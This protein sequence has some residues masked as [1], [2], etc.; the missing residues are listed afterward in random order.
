MGTYP[1]NDLTDEDN[2]T[3][4]DEKEK[5]AAPER[6]SDEVM[7][8]LSTISLTDYKNK[9]QEKYHSIIEQTLQFCDEGL[10][11]AHISKTFNLK[12][13]NDA[14]EYIKGKM[15]TGKVL[16]EIEDED[17]DKDEAEK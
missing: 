14:I 4:K 2:E 7:D 9:D 15:C 1:K 13:V 8:R 3:E 6:I 12:Q 17:D 5:K 11:T 10:I 16:I